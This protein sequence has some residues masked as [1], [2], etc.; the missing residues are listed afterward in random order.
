MAIHSSTLAWK[1][2]GQRSLVGY[3]PWGCEESDTTERLHFHPS[4]KQLLARI[5]CLYIPYFAF[6]LTDAT[7]F[8]SYLRQHH[9]PIHFSEVFSYICNIVN[10]VLSHSTFHPGM[11]QHPE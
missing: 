11:P 7:Y 2:P 6:S 8:Q 9:Y 4:G 1:I 10:I 5:R 3:S